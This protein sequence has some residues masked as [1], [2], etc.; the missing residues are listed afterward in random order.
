MLKLLFFGQAL[1]SGLHKKK[2]KKTRVG[3]FDFGNRMIKIET[4]MSGEYFF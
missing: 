2:K 1:N 3:G 4:K